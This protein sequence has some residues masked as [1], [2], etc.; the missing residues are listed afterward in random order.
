MLHFGSD[1]SLFYQLLPPANV[2]RFTIGRKTERVC[3]NPA[4]WQRRS[5]LHL[6]HTPKWVAVISAL[7]SGRHVG[8]VPE[9]AVSAQ[10]VSGQLVRVGRIE[11]P[12]RYWMFALR[13]RNID[14]FAS[15]LARA[16]AKSP[17]SSLA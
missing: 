6:D 12:V 8:I 10:L 2:N 11:I 4:L 13:E 17:E 16:A 5:K 3:C 9:R 1:R 15:Q 7:K 14:Q